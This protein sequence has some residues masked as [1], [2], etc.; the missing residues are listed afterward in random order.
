MHLSLNNNELEQ[1]IHQTETGLTSSVRLADGL[2]LS[3]QR[4]END[5]V[6]ELL[7]EQHRFDQTWIIQVLKRRYEYPVYFHACAPLCDLSG[8]WLLRCALAGENTVAEGT[9]RLL[10]LAGIDIQILFPR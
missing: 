3:H 8:N 10:E 9:Q 7:A 6:I 1:W 4:I 5:P 2:T